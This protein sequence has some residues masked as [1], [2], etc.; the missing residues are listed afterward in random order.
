MAM[1]LRLVCC[2]V[3]GIFVGAVGIGGVLLIPALMIFSGL[4]VHQA[5]A[6][7]LFTFLF[8]GVLGSW[9][10][11]RR[12]TIEWH[13]SMPVC[14]GAF[15]LSFIGA[16]VGARISPLTLIWVVAAILLG[17]GF[18]ILLPHPKQIPAVHPRDKSPTLTGA[19]I[20]NPIQQRF[21]VAP[22]TRVPM[23]GLANLPGWFP[24]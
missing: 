19:Q 20:R 4:T 14:V 6:T 17:A 9:L 11:T 21:N 2:L 15:V 24:R 1:F 22:T 12:G 13:I 5:A 10:F 8:T 18:Y 16:A 7:A 3:V 23:L